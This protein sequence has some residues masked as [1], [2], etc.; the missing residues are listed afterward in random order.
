MTFAPRYRSVPLQRR[1]IN[2]IIHF[3]MKSHVVGCNWTI[4]VAPVVTARAAVEPGIGWTAIWIRALALVSQR[5]PVL[6]T[7]YL[8]FPWARLYVHPTGVA[9]VTVERTW[10]GEAAVFFAQSRDPENKSLAELDQEL[11]NLRLKRVEDIRSFRRLIYSSRAPL[12]IR[13]VMWSVGLHWSGRLRSRYFGTYVINPFPTRGEIMQSTTPITLLIYYGLIGANGDTLVQMLYDHRVLDGI[14][15]YRLIRDVE[16][17]MNRE[18]V[19][20]LNEWAKLPTAEKQQVG[21][22]D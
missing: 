17:T 6:R 12:L 20:E 7:A 4:N 1:W 9:A 22:P 5:R 2:D 13:R 3:G 21:A 10:R 16:A 18:I 11:R 15:A 8:P 14:E 19:A